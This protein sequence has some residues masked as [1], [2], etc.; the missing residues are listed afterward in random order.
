[1][2]KGLFYI[3]LL[4][5]GVGLFA[6]C[7]SKKAVVASFSDLD[8]EWGVVEMN[9]KTLNPEET[10]QVLVFDVA[11]QGLSGNAG[12][13]RL[14]GKIEYNDAYK[15]IIIFLLKPYTVRFKTVQTKGKIAQQYAI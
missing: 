7:K 4:L 8:G 6:G 9:G 11:R 15:N 10:H 1:M 14:M 3:C 2:R 13:N 12:C 5:V